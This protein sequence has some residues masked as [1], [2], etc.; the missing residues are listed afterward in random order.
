MKFKLT[1]LYFLFFC[2]NFSFGQLN[3]DLK[4]N[5]T[6]PFLEGS[7]GGDAEIGINKVSLYVGVDF[8]V[9]DVIPN[10]WSYSFEQTFTSA[11]SNLKAPFY[12]LGLRFYR[13][14]FYGN[15]QIFYALKLK[16]ALDQRKNILSNV[17]F[18]IGYKHISKRKIVTETYLGI[19]PA[20]LFSAQSIFTKQPFFPLQLG[21]KVGYRLVGSTSFF[22]KKSKKR[23]SK[24][25]KENRTPY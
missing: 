9:Q 14:P 8:P 7:V 5:V 17:F 24:S 1:V 3:L 13:N 6:S 20:G 23:K 11:G 19:S 15:D 2:L 12:K 10:L 4:T 18:N 25:T 22:R 21:F 16:L